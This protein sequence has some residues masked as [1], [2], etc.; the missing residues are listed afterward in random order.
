MYVPLKEGRAV[1]LIAHVDAL[2]ALTPTLSVQ[3]VGLYVVR[4]L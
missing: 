1:L 3:G 2:L 4:A